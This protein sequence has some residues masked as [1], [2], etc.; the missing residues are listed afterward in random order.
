LESLIVSCNR[1]TP[2]GSSLSIGGDSKFD[3]E[4]L[5]ELCGASGID[6]IP[7]SLVKLLLY[8]FD[9]ISY[10][11]AL[12][13]QSIPVYLDTPG[14]HIHERLIEVYSVIICLAEGRLPGIGKLIYIFHKSV[15]ALQRDEGILTVIV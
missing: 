13:L 4:I 1:C 5:L 12:D 8:L 11:F 2:G 3:I 15:G 14:H 10:P 6:V 9:P 7:D